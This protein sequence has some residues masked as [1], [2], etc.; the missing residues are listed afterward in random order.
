MSENMNNEGLLRIQQLLDSQ[1]FVEFGSKITNRFTKLCNNPIVCESDGVVTGYG[2]MNGELVFIFAQD[3]QCLGGSFGEMHCKKIAHLFQQAK[4]MK[5]PVIGI[6]NSTGIRLNEGIMGLEGLGE[7]LFAM[8]EAQKSIPV[9]TI[10]TG[11]CGGSLGMIPQMSDF[12]FLEK[13]NGKCFVNSINTI[14]NNTHQDT[15]DNNTVPTFVDFIGTIDDIREKINFLCERMPQYLGQKLPARFEL[16]DLNRSCEFQNSDKITLVDFLQQVSD[17]ASIFPIKEHGCK[18]VFTGFIS[19]AGKLV[20]VVATLDLAQT[21]H[22]ECR[23][24]DNGMKKATKMVQLCNRFRIP[25]L[26]ILNNDGIETSLE[27]EEDYLSSAVLYFDAI[28]ELQSPKISLIPDHIYGGSYSFMGSKSIGMDMVIGWDCAQIGVLSD[29]AIA[30]LGHQTSQI[31]NSI[32]QAAR[33]G[34]VDC[35]ILPN[36]TRSYLI[37]LFD[38]LET[39]T[40]E[41]K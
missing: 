12:V 31:D 21:F 37:S 8:K 29:V 33:M 17:S 35:I 28:K 9:Y 5:A 3:S 25:L 41:V 24:N 27:N 30:K 18:D 16:D 40:M 6:I 1:S 22:Q 39:K 23:L 7:V 32:A 14:S 15:I 20:G 26:S 36:Q 19:L 11:I 13:T 4:K 10:I 34:L 38:M 2:Q